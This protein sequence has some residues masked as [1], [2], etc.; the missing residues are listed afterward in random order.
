M[1]CRAAFSIIQDSVV[2]PHEFP[3]L[4]LH[5]KYGLQNS[6]RG[7]LGTSVRTKYV[8]CYVSCVC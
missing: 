3:S 4:S 1:C 2:L 7:T 8:E 5:Y 6:W